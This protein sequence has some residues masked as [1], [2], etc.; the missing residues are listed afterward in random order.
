[1]NEDNLDMYDLE[2]AARTVWGEARGEPP[3][4]RLAVA[5]VIVNRWRAGAAPGYLAKYAPTTPHDRCPVS[6][7]I[8]HRPS[9]SSLSGGKAASAAATGRPTAANRRKASVVPDVS[10]RTTTLATVPTNH[11][12]PPGTI[13]PLFGLTVSELKPDYDVTVYCG[14]PAC[15][16]I[17]PLPLAKLIER[18]PRDMLVKALETRIRCTQ[19]QRFE[20]KIQI[21]A[22]PSA[23]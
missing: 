2:V 14:N 1:M 19:C 4:G 11:I 10:A 5:R 21:S 15:K 23:R 3:E 12:P 18:R 13:V 9:H 16:R 6:E 17:G 20:C 8:G 22:G 7:T